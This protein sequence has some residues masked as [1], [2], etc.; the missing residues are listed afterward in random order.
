MQATGAV[1]DWW[2]RQPGRDV[3]DGGCH[4]ATGTLLYFLR[5]LCPEAS[6]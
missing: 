4:Q 1:G 5:R 2:F 3:Y 6:S